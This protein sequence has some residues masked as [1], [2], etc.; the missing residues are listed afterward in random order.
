MI[1]PDH[2]LRSALNTGQI[3]VEPLAA[4]AIQP[5]S[6]DLRLGPDLLIATPDGFR[7]HDLTTSP[8]HLTQG[9]FVLG[10]TLEWVAVPDDLV[11][12]LVGKSSRAREGIQIES[13]GYC[14]PGW[15]GNLTLEITMLAPLPDVW[16]MAGM[17]I[18]QIRFEVLASRCVNPY[19]SKGV[20][21][22][23]DSHGPVESRAVVGRAS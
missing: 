16:L 22:Y 18:A 14:D 2:E 17:L 12:V 5:S 4:D 23:Q 8:F 10:A 11:G 20:G 3:K 15:R 9:A 6:I 1:L 7:S 13:A 21:R 19:G